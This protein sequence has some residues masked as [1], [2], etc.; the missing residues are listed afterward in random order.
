MGEAPHRSAASRALFAQ[1]AQRALERREPCVTATLLLEALWATPTPAMIEVMGNAIAAPVRAL[2][3]APRWI[4][5]GPDLVEWA[6]SGKLPTRPDRLVEGKALYRVLSQPGTRGVF[7]VGG[8]A[9]ADAIFALAHVMASGESRPRQARGDS[10]IC[11]TSPGTPSHRNH[12]QDRSPLCWTR[13]P[14]RRTTSFWCCPPC[15]KPSGTRNGNR[16]I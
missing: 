1:V 13:L 14:K 5:Q 6:A 2:S 10:S 8:G 7:L 4:A 15:C 9:V 11:A 16:R 3:V 12:G